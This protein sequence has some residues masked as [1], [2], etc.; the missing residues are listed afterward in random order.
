MFLDL[1]G[2]RPARWRPV[3]RKNALKPIRAS[4]RSL[5]P[6]A[7]RKNVLE[8]IRFQIYSQSDSVSRKNV[9]GSIGTCIPWSQ[10]GSTRLLLLEAPTLGVLSRRN[11]QSSLCAP[12]LSLIG[13]GPP[14]ECS[15]TYP[16][17]HY[18]Q[19]DF[20]N[21]NNV[22]GPILAHYWSHSIDP[23]NANGSCFDTPFERWGSPLD[24]P[25]TCGALRRTALPSRA[26]P[27]V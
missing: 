10:Y 3:Y 7:Y 25:H 21:P 17:C 12:L 19:S 13:A 20:A 11:R 14:E 9:P 18:S 22:H 2:L 16:V 4:P 27:R 1:S 26:H 23:N 24:Y 8:P 6:A 5:A 15:W